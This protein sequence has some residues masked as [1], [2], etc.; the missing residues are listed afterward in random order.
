MDLTGEAFCLV[1]AEFC[2]RKQ[3]SVAPASAD[4]PPEQCPWLS[5]THITYIFQKRRA[6]WQTQIPRGQNIRLTASTCSDTSPGPMNPKAC[7]LALNSVG[8]PLHMP[9]VGS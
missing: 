8:A 4:K 9:G 3:S 6:M 5:H 7:L 2:L 1:W